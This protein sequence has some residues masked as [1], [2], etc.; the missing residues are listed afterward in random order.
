MAVFDHYLKRLSQRGWGLFSFESVD[1]ITGS[2]EIK[3]EYSSFVLA[4]PDKPGKLCYMFA[5]WFAGAMDWV[6]QEK[7][8]SAHTNCGEVSC[9]ETYCT[10]SQCGASGNSHCI[11]SVTPLTKKA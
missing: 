5:G 3:L 1:P 9:A 4:Q 11:F 6:T 7:G 2:A 10:E 8:H